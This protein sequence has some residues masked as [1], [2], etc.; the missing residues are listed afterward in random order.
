MKKIAIILGIL[1][2]IA[3]SL[4][5]FYCYHCYRNQEELKGAMFLDTP[6][7]VDHFI[8][9]YGPFCNEDMALIT[10]AAEE[11]RFIPEWETRGVDGFIYVEVSPGSF[12]DPR[13][14]I[15]FI[16]PSVIESY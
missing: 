5:I 8:E 9:K 3:G 2:I 14:E 1:M 4:Y 12:W 6:D 7:E 15:D 13:M 10:K 16:L 11:A